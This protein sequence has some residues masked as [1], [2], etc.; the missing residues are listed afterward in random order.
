MSIQFSSPTYQVNEGE[1]RLDAIITRSGDTSAAASVNF[2]TSDLAGAQNCNL[3]NGAASSRCDYETRLTTLRF[4]A[5]E[6]AKVVSV[7]IIDDAYLEG[8][9]TFNINLSN[10]IGGSLGSNVSATATIVDNDI[11]TGPTPL[12]QSVFFVRVH[13]LDFLNRLPDNDGLVFW[14]NE[15]NSCGSNQSCLN[16]KR[17]NVSA[18]FYLS[19][20]FQQTGYLVERTYKSAYGN[21]TGTSTLG[22]SHQLPVPVVQL[23]EFLADSQQISAGVIVGQ[24]TWQQTLENNKQAFFADFVQRTRFTTVFPTSLS[25]AQFVD[26]LNA[27]AENPLSSSERNQLVNDLGTGAKTRAQVLRAV[28][29]NSNLAKAEMNRALVLMQYFGYLRRNPNDSPDSDHT[30]YDFWLTKLNQFN[31]DFV[32]A[33]MVKAFLNSDEYRRRFGTP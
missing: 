30:G 21:A 14:T 4:A 19:I 25:A 3:A 13:Y 27:N 8:P 24:S 9:E 23:N 29:E 28:A 18:A 16:A 31:G 10:P 33:E 12:D 11:A 2:A 15:I 26:A 17:I 20:E 6:T 1:G 5:G 7:L 32:A 22:A